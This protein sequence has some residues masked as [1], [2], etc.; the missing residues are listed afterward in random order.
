MDFSYG[1]VSGILAMLAC[2]IEHRNLSIHMTL[3]KGKIKDDMPDRISAATIKPD[4]VGNYP[5]K[6]VYL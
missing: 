3:E 2:L 1:V 6:D 5:V 4:I